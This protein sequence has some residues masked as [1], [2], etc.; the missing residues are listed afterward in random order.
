[1]F[2]LKLLGQI[3]WMELF[4]PHGYYKREAYFLRNNIVVQN[5][6]STGLNRRGLIKLILNN[7][8]NP[9]DNDGDDMK[10][11]SLLLR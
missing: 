11:N 2:L 3:Q 4:M 1:M 9:N 5:K 6:I 10:Y 8:D 7:C